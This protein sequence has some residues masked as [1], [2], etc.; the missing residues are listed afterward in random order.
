MAILRLQ[1]DVS[2]KR[3]PWVVPLESGK[4]ARVSK[5]IEDVRERDRRH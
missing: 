1:K 4:L 3:L 5:G 2:D